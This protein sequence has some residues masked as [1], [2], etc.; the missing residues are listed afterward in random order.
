MLRKIVSY[1]QDEVGDWVAV[2]E[3]GHTQHIRHDPPLTERPWV[4]TPEGRA[5]FIGYPLNCKICDG[6]D[7]REI[8]L[9]FP[10]E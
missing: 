4:L 1:R 8:A 7:I 3:C 6:E 9:P 2:L 10:E 5:R